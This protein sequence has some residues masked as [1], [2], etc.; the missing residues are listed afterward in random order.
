MLGEAVIDDRG[1]CDQCFIV[2]ALQH[3]EWL[4]LNFDLARLRHRRICAVERPVRE[5]KARPRKRDGA[6][7]QQKRVAVWTYTMSA[8]R[9]GQHP[10]SS[11]GCGSINPNCGCL[12]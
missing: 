3:A 11:H 7:Q 1:R 4:K 12:P 9:R 5:G 2:A 8:T 10:R 6:A